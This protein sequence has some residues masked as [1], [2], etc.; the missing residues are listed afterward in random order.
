M[1]GGM[2]A[3][4]LDLAK[5][6]G[7]D[8]EHYFGVTTRVLPDGKIERDVYHDTFGVKELLLRQVMDT[9][10]RQVRDAL[11]ALGWTPP[12]KDAGAEPEA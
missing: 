3:W 12:S 11:I 10:D 6:K 4:R 7:I 5:I 2:L 1:C 8:M 9:L